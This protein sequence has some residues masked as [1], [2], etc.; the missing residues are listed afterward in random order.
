MIFVVLNL[1]L[2]I[3]F[4]LVSRGKNNRLN[5]VFSF[6]FFE[7]MLNFERLQILQ[8]YYDYIQKK[9]GVRDYFL[10]GGALRDLLLGVKEKLDDVDLTIAGEPIGLYAQMEKEAFSHFITEKF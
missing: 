1:I 4:S 2:S 3:G 7:N 5:S 9:T 6:L 8:K 10:V